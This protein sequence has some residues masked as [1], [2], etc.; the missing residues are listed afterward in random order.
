M[1]KV[2]EAKKAVTESP[3]VCLTPSNFKA[4]KK[5]PSQMLPEEIREIV[6]CGWAMFSHIKG[7]E[8]PFSFCLWLSRWIGRDGLSIQDAT[9]IIDRMTMPEN[10]RQFK[11]ASDVMAWLANEAAEAIRRAKLVT[12]ARE[13][14]PTNVKPEERIAAAEAMSK[15]VREL[16]GK[17]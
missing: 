4:I 8:E 12:E 14:A 5:Q 6:F 2:I 7:L 11:F 3:Q 13:L 1:S 9:R 17:P 10:A 15:V 16:F